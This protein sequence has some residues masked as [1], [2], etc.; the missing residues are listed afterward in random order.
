MVHSDAGD[1]AV[2]VAHIG[3]MPTVCRATATVA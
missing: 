3:T 1:G 2:T